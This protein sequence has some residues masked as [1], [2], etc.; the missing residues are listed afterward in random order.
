MSVEPHPL[1][2]VLTAQPWVLPTVAGVFGAIIG[3]FLN[4]VIYRV[5]EGLSVVHP[6]SRCPGCGTTVAWYDNIPVLSWMLLRGRCRGCRSSI[7]VRYPAV[8]ALTAGLAVAI[9]LREGPQPSALVLFVFV[10]ALVVITFIDLDW[11]IIP[12]AITF[13]GIVL[14]FALSPLGWS[15][16]V[17]G[18]ALGFGGL[19]VVALA[20]W[21]VRRR[22]GLGGG[23]IK[24]MGMVGAL[25]GPCAALFTLLAGALSGAIVG[26][27]LMLV[28][29]ESL[30]L[31][32]PFGPFLALGAVGWVLGG[33][34][35][36]G[37]CP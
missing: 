8:E 14:G 5:P 21:L 3:S 28:R 9:A 19:W 11:F 37:L 30:K 33:G 20:Y 27:G 7:S 4:V 16:R 10:A 24:L 18:F 29:G 34:R 36:L 26:I 2:L 17:A 13:P 22:E 6:G 12:D 1:V 23:D 35:W 15:E 32:I 31:A 25:L